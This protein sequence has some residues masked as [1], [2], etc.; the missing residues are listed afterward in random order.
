MERKFKPTSV[1]LQSHFENRDQVLL[2]LFCSCTLKDCISSNLPCSRHLQNVVV[3]IGF[4]AS[5]IGIAFRKPFRNLTSLMHIAANY[6]KN[7]TGE[8][9]RNFLGTYVHNS[10]LCVLPFNTFPFKLNK[11]VCIDTE[12]YIHSLLWIMIA[13]N[14][15]TSAL[16]FLIYKKMQ[17]HPPIT[18]T[19]VTW[20]NFGFRG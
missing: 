2:F 20:A 1:A 5:R 14:Y 6:L 10:E 13:T 12:S 4:G 3:V 15:G 11:A 19:I 16:P 18:P 8:L 17:L 9:Y 7:K